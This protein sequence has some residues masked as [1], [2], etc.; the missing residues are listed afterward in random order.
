M[1]ENNKTEKATPQKVRKEREKG[2]IAK[3]KELNVFLGLIALAGVVFFYADKLVKGMV[4]L[5]SSIF[6]MIEGQVSPMDILG[7]SF[8][9][10]FKILIPVFVIV[11]CSQI[12][13]YVL[14][15]RFLFSMKIIVPDFKKMNPVNYVKNLFSMKTIF[16]IIKNFAI[17]GLL[18]YVAY[19]ILKKNVGLFAESIWNPW[20]YTIETTF[21]VFKD[22]FFAILAVLLV[23]AAVDFIFTKWHHAKQIRMSKDDVKDERKNTDGNP[24]IKRR[25]RAAMMEMLQGDLNPK[26]QESQFI[27]N[28]PTHISV[29]IKYRHGIDDI[30]IVMAKGEEQLALYIRKL[31]K[32]YDI[33]MVENKPL[34]RSIYY[35]IEPGQPISEDLYGAVI[36]VLRY[37]I[38]TKQLEYEN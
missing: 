19:S 1:A 27:I 16:E 10:S 14:Q 12:I 3:S 21:V 33:P 29:A 32:E 2:N 6:S 5:I 36:G 11:T 8:M 15:V 9:E 24:E 38:E 17:F 25:Q 34:A 18:G 13:N 28:N 4:E 26:I 22:V 23:I 7:I 20:Q 37:L 35:N 31:A 30:P